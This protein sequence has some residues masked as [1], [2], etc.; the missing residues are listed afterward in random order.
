MGRNRYIENP[1][2]NLPRKLRLLGSQFDR[3]TVR[4]SPDFH[5]FK[6]S[7]VTSAV[8][9]KLTF[10]IFEQWTKFEMNL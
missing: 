1:R 9:I 8:Y 7:F 6:C 10:D 5:T 2:N 3:A 4:R